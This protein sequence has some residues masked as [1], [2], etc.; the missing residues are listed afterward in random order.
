MKTRSGMEIEM[1]QV[2]EKK[3]GDK[4]DDEEDENDGP[5]F[6]LPQ[7]DHLFGNQSNGAVSES[8]GSSDQK[9]SVGAMVKIPN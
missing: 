2:L 6:E 1:S 8:G 7:L 9:K 5:G 4:D 3:N